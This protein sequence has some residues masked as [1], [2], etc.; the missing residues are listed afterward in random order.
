MLHKK[1]I[2]LGFPCSVGITFLKSTWP[3]GWKWHFFRGGEFSCTC[4]AVRIFM[5]RYQSTNSFDYLPSKLNVHLHDLMFTFKNM[6]FN[7]SFKTPFICLICEQI[8]MNKNQNESY[9]NTDFLRQMQFSYKNIAVLGKCNC[10]SF[11]KVYVFKEIC[12]LLRRTVFLIIQFD[13][14]LRYVRCDVQ[15]TC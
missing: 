12:I 3:L 15:V 14:Y 6:L 9:N 2:F 13:F 10:F 5:A 8:N 11:R 7:V 4:G 1:H